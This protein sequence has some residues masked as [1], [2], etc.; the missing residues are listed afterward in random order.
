MSRA[1]LGIVP[2]LGPALQELM[3]DIIP[4]QRLDRMSQ[5]LYELNHRVTQIE[6]FKDIIESNKER[7]ILLEKAIAYS[8][9]T[10]S[11]IKSIGMVNVLLDGILSDETSLEES[12]Q[13]LRI[14]DDIS[15]AQLII[16]KYYYL[17]QTGDSRKFRQKHVKLFKYERLFVKASIADRR[18][19]AI[20][21]SNV[22]GLANYGLLKRTYT[23]P[24]IKFGE[25]QYPAE[26]ELNYIISD[27]GN[28]LIE[29]VKIG[30]D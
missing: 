9:R 1:I 24:D 28:M 26:P 8:A 3:S 10:N 25:E 23:W 14:L 20:Y 17:S 5:F 11:N 6:G 22:Q 16:L 29:S 7:I 4:N 15:E 21:M 2:F 27:M 12:A 30:D 19:H 18:G 13:F